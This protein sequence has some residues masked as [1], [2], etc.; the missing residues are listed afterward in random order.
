MFLFDALTVTCS[1]EAILRVY[2]ADPTPIPSSS[3]SSS[4]TG[5]KSKFSPYHLRPPT[6]ERNFLISPPGSPPVG[7]EP[8]PEEPPNETPLADDLIMALRRLQVTQENEERPGLNGVSVLIEPE[9]GPG[10]G[11][12]VE[13]CGEP[14]ASCDGSDSD[15]MYQE[16]GW[17]Y[18]EPMQRQQFIS[19]A[20]MRPPMPTSA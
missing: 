8:I 17:F 6:I 7:W 12:Y 4:P 18:G 2:R 20:T 5:T 15:S 16:E 14:D 1:P 19:A 10:V 13:D 3:G 11:V 9:E